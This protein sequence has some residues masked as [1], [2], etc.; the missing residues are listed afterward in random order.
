M[1][2]KIN[3]MI[4]RMVL[5]FC[6]DNSKEQLLNYRKNQD[7]PPNCWNN[8]KLKSNSLTTKLNSLRKFKDSKFNTSDQSYFKLIRPILNSWNRFARNKNTLETGKSNINLHT[9]NS[10]RKIKHWKTLS[11]RCKETIVE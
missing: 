11:N 2:T 9:I 10:K 8:Y 5:L 4:I 3:T 1:N 7:K 6:I